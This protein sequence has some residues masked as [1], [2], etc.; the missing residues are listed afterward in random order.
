M[1]FK[2]QDLIL[3]EGSYTHSAPLSYT[4]GTMFSS[5]DSA[6]TWA[7]TERDENESHSKVRS[8]RRVEFNTH[9]YKHVNPN[10]QFI[11]PKDEIVFAI[12][13]MSWSFHFRKWRM[14]EVNPTIKT[15]V[16]IYKPNP[17]TTPTSKCAQ[18]NCLPAWS[19]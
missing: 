11:R 14:S 3:R 16:H 13:L 2:K 9:K 5:T 8:S 10:S 15:I 1:G 17:A 6:W 7:D 12:D 18:S 19:F 4:A